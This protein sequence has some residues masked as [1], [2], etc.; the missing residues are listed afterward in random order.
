M[1]WLSILLVAVVFCS[2]YML[3][4]NYRHGTLRKTAEAN[5]VLL[6]LRGT[7]NNIPVGVYIKNASDDLRY[8]YINDAAVRFF[9]NSAEE[10]RG[11]TD[12]QVTSR[13]NI[14]QQ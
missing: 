6:L 9:N 1:G 3:Y 7:F 4:H 11:K 2:V 10:I 8:I 12:F 14:T 5:E 13:F